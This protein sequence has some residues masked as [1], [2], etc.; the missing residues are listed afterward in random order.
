[1]K[2]Y[3]YSSYILSNRPCLETMIFFSILKMKNPILNLKF[4]SLNLEIFLL[5]TFYS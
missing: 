4:K 2:C 1:M 3:N 5:S